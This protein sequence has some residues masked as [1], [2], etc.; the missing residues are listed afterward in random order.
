[1]PLEIELKQS[2]NIPLEVERIRP[3][4][5]KDLSIA[6]IQRV[7]IF[8]G[9]EE[10]E[11]GDFFQVAGN[12]ADMHHRW[13][14]DCSGVHWIGAEMSAG[15]IDIQGEAG[16]HLGSEMTGG[17][18]SVTGN[19]SDW[20]GAEMKG[21]FIAVEGNAGHLIGAAYRGSP[22]G[23]TGGT[24]VIKGST[25]N[26]IGHT[27]R[28]GLIA[29]G[30]NGDLAGFNMLAG[31][32]LI[33]GDTGIRHG[34]GMRRGTLGFFGQSKPEILPTFKYACRQKLDMLRIVA[35]FLRDSGFDFP[36]PDR[37]DLFHG[38][39]LDGGRGE[40]MLAA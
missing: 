10:I 35:N 9:K 19:T 6:E 20:V 1:M 5:V 16:R 28:R 27:M 13:N 38:D 14:G 17:R 12:A 39:F 11:F 4:L 37:V 23:M 32:I 18:I 29:V 36:F 22:K 7:K 40:V 3:D 25:G 21:G 34:A 8:H 2:T 31:T 24:I 30:S 15:R 33:F 26:E